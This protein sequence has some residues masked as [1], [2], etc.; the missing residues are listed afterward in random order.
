MTPARTGPRF[1][2]V[3]PERKLGWL[4]SLRVNPLPLLFGSGNSSI[5]YFARRDLLAEKSGPASQLWRL[6]GAERILGRQNADGSWAYPGGNPRIRT[7]ANY[8]QLETFRQLGVLVEEFG[9]SRRHPAL[10]R[11]C[12]FLFSFQTREGD[13]RGI[14]GA[15]YATTYVGA[16]LELVVKAGYARDQRVAKAFDW[17][18]SMR[19]NDGGWAIPARTAGAPFSALMDGKRHPKPIPRDATQPFSHLTTGMVLRA[20]A[21]HPTRRR[22]RA[23]RD[24]GAL[25]G[26]RLFKKDV[27]GDR[28]AATYWERVSFPFWF[29]DIV[30]ALDTLSLLG[31]GKEQ[32]EIASALARVRRAQRADGSFGF[33]LLKNKDPELPLWVCLAVCRSL[34][35][36]G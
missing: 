33:E 1:H 2:D 16:I 18:L 20:F 7:R 26:S 13:F 12:E 30:S 15:Q 6:P 9:L 25:L 36:F 19:Q 22:S 5:A 21:A 29:T 34:A 14:Y 27:Y 32:P 28:G 4:R 24:A 11:A 3:R 10:A 31:F 8:D 23:A 17:L 35:R